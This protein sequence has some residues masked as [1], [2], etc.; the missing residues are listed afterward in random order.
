LPEQ[1]IGT[2]GVSPVVVAK[3]MFKAAI[4]GE[5]ER[6]ST[7]IAPDRICLNPQPELV[8]HRFSGR[9]REIRAPHIEANR[10]NQIRLGL[11]LRPDV[12]C[13]NVEGVMPSLRAASFKVRPDR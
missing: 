10:T 2:P 13:L 9:S 6:M 3:V 5:F 7:A 1:A 8:D 11:L 12:Y 4:P